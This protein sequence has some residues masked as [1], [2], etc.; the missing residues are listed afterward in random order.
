VYDRNRYYDPTAR[1]FTQEDPIG[2]AGG[3]NQYGYAG[4]DPANSSDPFG[5]T[6]CTKEEE[7][8][9]KETVGDK[10]GS[11]C[12]EQRNRQAQA[13]FVASGEFGVAAGMDLSVAE[14]AY[15]VFAA[16][17]ALAGAVARTF[18]ADVTST[19]MK[20]G[21]RAADGEATLATANVLVNHKVPALGK[22]LMDGAPASAAVGTA[23]AGGK[24]TWQTLL[25]FTGY[26]ERSQKVAKECASFSESVVGK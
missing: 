25:P 5:L 3:L 2:L 14:A 24:F 12:V 20:A 7:Q 4:A 17:A 13:C 6:A 23:G 16:G 10:G 21:L 9:G 1:R 18:A 8:A 26:K 19:M 15:K 22:E 11:R